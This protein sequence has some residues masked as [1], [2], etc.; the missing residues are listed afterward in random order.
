ME[1]GKRIPRLLMVPL[2]PLWL[3]SNAARKP[4]SPGLPS[5]VQ[6]HR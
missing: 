3:L 4:L 2:A 6:D 1:L 5:H